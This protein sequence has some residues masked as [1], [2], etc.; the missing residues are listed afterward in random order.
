M[1]IIFLIQRIDNIEIIT[2]NLYYNKLFHQQD[3]GNSSSIKPYVAIKM[4]V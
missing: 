1:V 3:S 2:N 4:N